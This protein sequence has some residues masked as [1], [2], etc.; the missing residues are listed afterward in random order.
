MRLRV[1]LAPAVPLLVAAAAATALAAPAIESHDLEV[2]LTPAT[3]RLEA[4]D[5][6]VVRRD[7]GGALRFTLHAKL[8]IASAALDGAPVTPARGAAS[9][10]GWETTWTVA[11]PAEGKATAVLDLAYA[12]PVTDAIERHEGSFVV[13]DSTRGLIEPEGAYLS[14]RTAWVASDG[15]VARHRVTTHAVPGWEV[16]TQGTRTAP[17]EEGG[18]TVWTGKYPADGLD[19]VAGPWKVVRKRFGDVEVGCYLT[20]ANLAGADLLLA[21]AGEYL[22]KYGEMLG[23]YA[24]DRFDIVENF[25]TTGYGMPEFTLLG[26]N[27]I[28]RMLAEA[29]RK[30][31]IPA[32]YLDHEIVHCWWGNLVYPDYATG[33]WCEALTSY[34]ANYHAKEE[35]GPEAAAEHR[36]TTALR[37]TL[38]VHDGN[39]YPVREFRGKAEAADD[40]IGYGKGSM[41]FHALRRDLG[42]TAFWETLRRVAREHRGERFSWEDWRRE[43][44]ESAQR[45]LAEV[46]QQGLDRKGAPL[47]ELA[48]TRVASDGGRTRVMGVLRQKGVRGGA[49][50]WRLTVPVV[51]EHLD[52]REEVPVDLTG[53]ETA[54]SIVV[55][56]LP[57]RVSADPDH[58]VF[59]I[60]GPEEVPA[61]LAATLSRPKVVVVPAAGDEASESFAKFLVAVAVHGAVRPDGSGRGPVVTVR[62]DVEGLEPGA[63]YV[64]AGDPVS[65]PL[66]ARLRA[67]LPRGHFPSAASKPESAMVL[68]TAR[69]PADAAEFVTTVAAAPQVLAARGRFVTYYQFDGRVAFE[70]PAPRERAQASTPSRT[71]RFLLPDVR[72]ATSAERA[73]RVVAALAAPEMKGRLAGSPEEAAARKLV[74]DELRLAGVEPDE[75]PF[76]FAVKHVDP[77]ARFLVRADGGAVE[78]VL[79]VV[80]S[81][82]TPEEGVAVVGSVAGDDADLAGRALVV[83]L[84]AGAAKPMEFL[85]QAAQ[86]AV[87]RRASALFVRVA[88]DA[89]PHVADLRTFPETLPAAVAERL[90]AAREKGGD[91]DP[92]R[93][94]AGVAARIGADAELPLPAVFVPASFVP[95]K[96]DVLRLVVRFRRT[97]V[98]S[99]NV[100]GRVRT[101]R[102]PRPEGTIVL[103]AHLDHLGEGFPGGDDN[104]SGV[105]A[106]LEAVHALSAHADLL[107]QD[108]TVVF[109]GAEEWG[110]RGSRAFVGAPPAGTARIGAM[111]NADTVGRRGVDGVSVVGITMHPRLGRVVAAAVEQSH[112]AAGREI[113]RFAFAHGSDH[114]SFHEK[115]IPA[116]DL[117]SGDYGVMHTKGDT[118]DGVDADKVARIG[119]A[120]ALAAMGAPAGGF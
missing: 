91:G 66:L 75:V 107:A 57:L 112:L 119:R 111:I 105:A 60:L 14:G 11:V 28:A 117:W 42:E 48:E 61:C 30:G 40:D 52:G 33:N 8:E 19:L 110:L 22:R 37:Y 29:K 79:P 34:C 6:I 43:F 106:L 18:P 20:G 94:A 17:S 4:K 55:P 81:P 65:H 38:R 13:G 64:V 44:E 58:H 80:A 23:P 62:T 95:A 3:H 87:A 108:V 73:G 45:G 10:D 86:V 103:G 83:D 85:R 59:R 99:A 89:P 109:F 24:Y 26:G 21:H 98:R 39:D 15:G 7:G 16:V 71:T 116:V 113:D 49:A 36:R 82:E 1:P 92:L 118:P 51:V 67:A 53:P 50:P 68:A 54:F 101:S 9:S 35:Q 32:G 56:S 102:R 115:G 93:H 84:G 120:L 104:A 97:E 114:W 96:D 5:R 74:M 78:G 90:A 27:V 47:L 41:F 2:R 69:N 25:F 46:F 76:A 100:V 88:D 72:S 63:S 70:G 77:A 12:G 31:A